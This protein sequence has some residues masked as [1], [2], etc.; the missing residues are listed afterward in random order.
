MA[1]NMYR[2]G[3]CVYFETSSAA[4]YQIRRIEELCKTPT[5][6]VEAR[7]MCFY[8]RRDISQNLVSLADKH[9]NVHFKITVGG[10]EE[11]NGTIVVAAKEELNEK[12]RHQLRH[13]ELFLS[14]QCETLPATHIRGKCNIT[15]LNETEFFS[16][17][18]NRD[19]T[20][21][22]SLVYDPTQKTLLADRGEIRVGPRFQ[23][24]PTTLL[25]KGEND[26][27]NLSDLEDL[28]W[29]PSNSLTDKQIENFQIVARSVGTFARSLDCSSTVRQPSLHMSAAAAS[30]DITLFHAMNLLHKNNYAIADAISD[31]IPS[32][33]PVLCRDEMEEWSTSEANLFEE[34]LDKYGKDFIEIRAD[35][36][37]WKSHK[38]LIEYYYMWKTTDRY[39][40][41][42]RIKAAEAE[43]KLKQVYIPSYNKPNPAQ[44]PDKPDGRPC[45]SCYTSSSNQWYLWGPAVMQC[46]VCSSCWVYWKKYGGLK[47]PTNNNNQNS[48]NSG[49]N[50]H[51]HS[52]NS[53]HHHHQ[54]NANANNNNASNNI[55]KHGHS[56]NTTASKVFKCTVQ[57]CGKTDFRS[58]A[59]LLQHLSSVHG[60]SMTSNSPCPVMKTRAAFCLITTP[61][62]RISRQICKSSLDMRRACRKP[63]HLIN[64]ALVKQ[65]CQQRL[66][67]LMSKLRMLKSRQRI[68]M[69][70]V[71]AKLGIDTKMDK[72]S[73]LHHHSS[74]VLGLNG[75]TNS[76]ASGA[77]ERGGQS[78]KRARDN[79]DEGMPPAKMAP[80]L[81]AAPS[82]APSSSAAAAQ[83]SSSSSQPATRTGSVVKQSQPKMRG[84]TI[85]RLN[86]HQQQQSSN[87][88]TTN[89]NNN[90]SK[91]QGRYRQHSTFEALE[92]IFFHAT[93]SVKQVRKQMTTQD[94]KK[95]GRKPWRPISLQQSSSSQ[96]LPS[97]SSSSSS[98]PSSSQ[99]S[100]DDGAASNAGIVVLD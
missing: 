22:Y 37:P 87:N 92:D 21:F 38:S 46:R 45:E 82:L 80:P 99:T 85:N 61:L 54:N 95:G 16:S 56:S 64:T 89:A 60:M 84:S 50:S 74:K 36:L 8:R 71:S 78:K 2:V 15:L 33:G 4:P 91:Q 13:R 81:V 7:V 41:Q 9:Q 90:T 26:G 93:E 31:L 1:A 98:L 55:D 77:V 59:N 57:G 42:K 70:K 43:S 94:F 96:P 73:L 6:N 44:V 97:S 11:E 52:Q 76:G 69:E 5:G 10:S 83:L 19:D 32:T 63:F 66:P 100:G 17:Y 65:E 35:Y 47:I 58:K 34:A 53:N 20:F 3:D 48:S 67:E 51:H 40:Q 28:I 27:R 14:R 30:R 79:D 25:K 86:Q 88:S 75:D 49:N 62:T 29:D 72:P 68:P 39:I 18:L 23:A 12:Q 24:D